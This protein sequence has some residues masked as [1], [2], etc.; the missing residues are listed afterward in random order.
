MA[1]L[2]TERQAHQLGH[3]GYMPIAAILDK[4]KSKKAGINLQICITGK[5][6]KMVIVVDKLSSAI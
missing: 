1:H 2:E 4:E 5:M 6:E 3:T